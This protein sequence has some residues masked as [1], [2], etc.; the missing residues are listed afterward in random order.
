[1][2]L[3]L[4]GLP[5]ETKAFAESFVLPSFYQVINGKRIDYDAY[6]K[7]VQEWRG[8]ISEYKPKVYVWTVATQNQDTSVRIYLVFA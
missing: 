2:E 7:D 5:S 4:T 8:K 6:I 1:M 3:S